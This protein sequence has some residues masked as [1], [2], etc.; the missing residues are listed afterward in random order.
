MA[1]KVANSRRSQAEYQKRIHAVVEYIDRHL[2]QRLDLGTLAEVAN[3]SPFHFHRLFGALMGEAL[4]DYLRRR[5]LEVA[6]IRMR[7]QQ[8]VPVL[9]VALGV[10]FG[11]AEAFTRAF[12][13]RF[14]CSP[15][16]W[17]N[18]KNSQMPRKLDQDARGSKPKNATSQSKE[19]RMKVR[20]IEREPVHVAYLRHT[21]PYGKQ[22]GAF[23]MNTVAP[24]MATNNLMGRE[25]FGISLDDPIVTK[26]A[27]CRYDA[28]VTS[29]EGE[30]LT[31]NPQHKVIPGGK[32]AAMTYEGTGADIGV[33]WDALLREW[34]PKSGLQ[35]DARPF[36]EYYPVDGRYDPKTGAF[37]CDICVPVMP[38]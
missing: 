10:G 27:Q 38:L 25:R 28:C 8:L 33:A 1:P 13:A 15:T 5:R 9:D 23:W 34:L 7:S 37:T 30:V 19:S 26:P 4:G 32:Y 11:S 31:G 21:G 17:R 29:P 20:I 35:L 14:D 16:Q 3:F 12:R 6:A 18:R 2:D 24:W 36:F 22:I